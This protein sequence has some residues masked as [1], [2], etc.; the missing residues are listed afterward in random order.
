M[1]NGTENSS[2]AHA[3]VQ[4]LGLAG[5]TSIEQRTLEADYESNRMKMF[6][7]WADYP[8]LPGEACLQGGTAAWRLRRAQGRLSGWI[9]AVPLGGT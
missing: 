5:P 8:C 2:V 3:A 9:G 1:I 4:V 6:K 7:G